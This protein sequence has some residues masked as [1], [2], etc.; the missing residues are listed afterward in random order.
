MG[1]RKKISL[2][3]V[4]IGSILFLS[5]IISVFEFNRMRKS[6]T[7]LMTANINSIN[8]SRHLME[9]TDEYNLYLLRSVVSEPSGEIDIRKDNRFSVYVSRIKDNFSSPQEMAMADSLME[10]Y[11]KYISVVGKSRGIMTEDSLSRHLWLKEELEPVYFDLMKYKKELGLITQNALTN[12]TVDIQ[13]G[14]YRSIMPGIISV[15]AGIIL[16]LLFNYFLNVY[17][18]SPVLMISRGIR[19]YMDYR[20]S[21]NVKLDNDDEIE[22]LNSEVKSVLDENKKLKSSR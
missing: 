11:G 15:G 2:G 17:F 13:E 19:N 10:A 14:Y 22:D 18:I 7:G 16:V 21:Y 1:I 8:T 5:S 12:N 6:V 20:K 3:F 9:L 4:V